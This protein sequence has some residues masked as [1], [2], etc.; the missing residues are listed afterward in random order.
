MRK[1]KKQSQENKQTR[2]NQIIKTVDIN[3]RYN[4]ANVNRACMN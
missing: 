3:P 2:K 4:T 1:E